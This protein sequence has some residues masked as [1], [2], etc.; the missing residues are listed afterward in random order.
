MA[1]AKAPHQKIITV[2]VYCWNRLG[3]APDV[4]AA[5]TSQMLYYLSE[6]GHVKVVRMDKN[7]FFST[8]EG[9][10][11]SMVFLDAVH[12][13]DETKKDIE[14]AQRAGARTIAGHDYCDEF[15]GV[16]QVVDEFGGPAELG[17]T[18]WVL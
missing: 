9:P 18:V 14:W 8:Y 17:G 2:D 10:P 7:E 5:F 3:F 6:T 11:P 1:L 12:D 16:K 4:H 15:P 13:Y